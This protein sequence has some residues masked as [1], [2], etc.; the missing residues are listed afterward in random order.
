MTMIV[1]IRIHETGRTNWSLHSYRVPIARRYHH[2][3]DAE[4]RV[5]VGQTIWVPESPWRSVGLVD[6]ISWSTQKWLDSQEYE[7]LAHRSFCNLKPQ[8]EDIQ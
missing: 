6:E 7:R 3:D 4:Y 1:P 2:D 8:L 5:W